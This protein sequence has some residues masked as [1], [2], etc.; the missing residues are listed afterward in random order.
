MK[1][2]LSR[3]QALQEAALGFGGLALHSMM[4]LGAEPRAYDLRVRKPHF[5]PKAKNVIFIYVG[6][7]PSTIDMYDPKPVLKKYD[8]QAAPFEIKGRALNGS[9]QVMASPWAFT[10]CGQSG[11]EIS[12]LLPHFQ[13]V[14]DKV[15]FVR[16]MTT[17]RIDHSTAQFTFVTGRGFTGFPSIGAWV[18]YAL[19]SENQNMPGYIALG[20]GASIG[21]R[22]HSSAWLPPVYSGTAMRADAKSPI[23]D[24]KRPESITAEQQVKLLEMVKELNREQKAQHPLDQDMEARIS[25]YE[26]AA[27]MQVEAMRVADLSAETEATRNL[28]GCDD[29]ASG[30]FGKHCLMAR[31]LVESGV[32]FVQIYGGGGWDTHSSIVPQL[33]GLCH[34]IDQGMSALLADLDQRGMLNDTLVVWSGEFGRLPTI[35]ARTSS[36]GRDHNP[37]GFNMWMAGAGLKRGYDFGATDELGYAAVQEHRV[38]HAD[39]HATIQHLL[40]LDYQKNTF[41]YEGRDESLVGVTPA[42]VLK[43]LLA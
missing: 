11:R 28:Y 10:K 42:R 17:D 31:R 15:S 24:I 38:G 9:Q 8:G 3:R 21:T 30:Q 5:A 43:E 1:R 7:G 40:G 39:I 33:P 26:L 16:S 2:F 37:Y 29:K 27:R 19:G 4:A 20:E 23:Y 32:R 22:A 36:P 34:Y 41:F 18:N 14:V 25:N 6:G 13:K 12:N 35:E